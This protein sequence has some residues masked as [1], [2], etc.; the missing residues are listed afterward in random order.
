MPIRVAVPKESFAG[1]RRVALVPEAAARLVKQGFEVRVEQGAGLGA[2]YA[3]QLY[4]EAGAVLVGDGGALW[5]EAQILCK[6]QPPTEQE[7]GLLG[8]GAVLVSFLHAYR[9][10]GVVARL[11]DQGVTAFAMELVPRITRA[12]SM[13]ALS[14]QATVAGYKGTLMAAELCHRFFPML[15][16]AAGTIR[17]ARV[18]VLGA[19]VAGLQAI[20]TARRLGAMVEAYDVRHAAREQVE[21]LGAKFLQVEL[22]AE[23]EGGYARELTEEEKQREQAML[24]RSVEEADVVI[25]TAQIPGRDAP[26]LISAQ[27]VETMKPGAVVL[28]LAAESGGN[29][30]LTVPGEQVSHGEVTIFGPLNLPSHL[31]VHAS[32]MYAKN[33]SNFVGLLAPAEE[34]DTLTFDWDDEILAGSVVTHDGTIRNQ[35]IREMVEGGQS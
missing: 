6:V 13:D 10:P 30:E 8:R 3:D 34:G 12:Q 22:D 29:C 35:A 5:G 18:L 9:N 4:E 21:S 27:M 16:T 20:A 33:I 31:A 7:V 23:A 26:R 19:G 32:D 17:P 28:D 25:S 1:E 14:S 11:R 24:W 2:Y 15:T